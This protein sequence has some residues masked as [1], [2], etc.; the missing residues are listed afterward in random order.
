MELTEREKALEER[1]ILDFERSL[2]VRERRD[3]LFAGWAARALDRAD[4][5]AYADEIADAGRAEAGDD[6]VLRKVLRDFESA[7]IPATREQLQEKMRALLF[8]AA[9]QLDAES[10]EARR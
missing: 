5:T 10:T 9:E 6:D 2:R 8:V 3:S 7:G 4:A 1:Y